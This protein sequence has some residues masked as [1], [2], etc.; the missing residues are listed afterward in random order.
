MLV[1]YFA[2]G[3]NMSAAV[4]SDA[5]P[6]HRV[7]GSARLRGY[8]LAFTRKSSRWNSGVA[9]IVAA[10][11]TTVWGVLYEI[12]ETDL[13]GLDRKEGYGSAYTRIP[14]DV[15]LRG[16]IH[17]RA[18][19][20]TVISKEPSEIPPSSEYLDTLMK[21]AED[22][23]LPEN[24]VAFL[25]SLRNMDA[26]WYRKGFF[27]IPSESRS[28]AEGMYIVSLSRSAVKRLGL[29]ALAVVAHANKSCLA[30]VTHLDSLDQHTCQLDQ[31]IRQALGFP[32]RE[33]YGAFVTVHPVRGRIR[34]LP[35]VKPRSLVLPLYRASW[36]DSEKNICVLHSKN[37]AL[38]GLN[39]GNYVEI[40]AAM[41][42]E[43]GEYRV[44]RYTSRVFSG[45]ADSIIREGL[46]KTDY[47]L[48]GEIYA[49]M[50]CRLALGIPKD[51]YDIPVL[52]RPSVS[53]LFAGR[54]LYYGI[55]LFLSMDALLALVQEISSTSGIPRVVGLCVA[56]LV[57][58]IA[59]FLFCIFDI[60]GRVQF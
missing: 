48:V 44:R 12:D 40:S 3:S 2:Y 58:A 4:I 14:C 7:L 20:Y 25:E 5:C 39:E 23:E 29:G 43:D 10:P 57:A 13:A 47:P 41:P 33:C 51:V 32:G 6:T 9:D 24:Y 18:I 15:S 22:R 28:K 8:R 50:H 31:T 30:K 37:I 34:A 17:H 55:A 27:T 52:V 42:G 19:T 16:R 26:R 36:L 60:R 59:T 11:E 35:F 53:R 56:L 46:E 45:S 54:L 1:R 49:D 21:G 38:L